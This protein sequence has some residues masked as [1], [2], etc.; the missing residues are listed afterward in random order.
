MTN[1]KNTPGAGWAT[2]T[3]AMFQLGKGKTL[4]GKS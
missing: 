3:K 1:N 4:A 2:T